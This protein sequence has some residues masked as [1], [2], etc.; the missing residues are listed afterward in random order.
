MTYRASRRIWQCGHHLEFRQ[1][2]VKVGTSFGDPFL[3]LDKWLA[4]V[5]T[6]ANDTN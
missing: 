3:P 1:F 4:A 5:W 6:V 2:T